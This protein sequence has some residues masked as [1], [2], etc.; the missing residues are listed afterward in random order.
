MLTRERRRRRRRG[1][2]RRRRRE[3]KEKHLGRLATFWFGTFAMPFC[4]TGCVVR[5]EDEWYVVI[6]ATF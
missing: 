2:R 6:K 5:H 4:V 1:R 3:K